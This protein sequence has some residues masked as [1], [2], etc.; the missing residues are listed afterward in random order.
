M[1]RFCEPCDWSWCLMLESE[2]AFA[3]ADKLA[4]VTSRSRQAAE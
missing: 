1:P 2:S 3:L 4:S